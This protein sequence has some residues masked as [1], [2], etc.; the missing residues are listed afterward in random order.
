[1]P[2]ADEVIDEIYTN[3]LRRMTPEERAE[4]LIK[5]ASDLGEVNGQGPGCATIERAGRCEVSANPG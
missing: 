1:V 4:E 2:T 5:A 3:F